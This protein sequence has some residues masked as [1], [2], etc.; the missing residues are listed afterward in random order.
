MKPLALLKD[1]GLE[2]L[3]PLGPAGYQWL[4]DPNSLKY[5]MEKILLGGWVD[6]VSRFMDRFQQSKRKLF[7]ICHSETGFAICV[8]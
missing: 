3:F 2:T 8:S 4:E 6:F 1:L 7:L 5:V